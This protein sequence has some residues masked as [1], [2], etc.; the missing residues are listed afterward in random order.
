M[1]LG[2]I[3]RSVAMAFVALAVLFAVMSVRAL[4][5]ARAESAE[6]SVALQAGDVELAIV[7]L[8]SAARWVAPFNGYASDALMRLEALAK[9][10]EAAGLHVRALQGYR[11]IHAAIHAGRSFY[12]PHDALLQRA[13]VRI[14]AL[15][16]A[17]PPAKIEQGRSSEQRRADYLALLAPSGPRPFGVLLA[18]AGFAAWVGS[19]ALF[20]L[21]GVDAEGRV[22]KH[23]GRRSVLFL[24]LGWIAFAVGLRIA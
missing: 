24:L 11:A 21:W 16:A 12:V 5:E 22:L 4:F 13:D 20:L 14:A 17:E 10:D 19:A 1:M 18:F 3:A 15:M 8:R 7:H 23:V 6:A 2:P 9:A